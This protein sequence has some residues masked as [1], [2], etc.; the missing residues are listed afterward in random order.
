M[1]VMPNDSGATFASASAMN[2]RELAEQVAALGRDD[3]LR[4]ILAEVC[5][6]T[7]MGFSAV[8]Y[9]SDSRWIACQV[10]DRIEFGLDPGDELEIRKTI[11]T[12]VRRSGHAVLIDDTNADPDWWSHP[13]P[14]LYGFRAYVSLPLHVDGEFFG[15]LCVID[16]APCKRP[17]AL[18]RDRLDQLA[19]RAAERLRLR[20][21]QEVTEPPPALA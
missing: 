17:I 10:D 20:L 12:E 6:L 16:P 4:A 5:A 14:V 3:E 8:A 11:C 19:A 13:L 21:A 2:A 1:T 15:T 9:V 18:S 7:G